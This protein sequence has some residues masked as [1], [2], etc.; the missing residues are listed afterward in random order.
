[1]ENYK[2]LLEESRRKEKELIGQFGKVSKK[3]TINT[4][5]EKPTPSPSHKRNRSISIEMVKESAHKRRPS[6]NSSG[7]LLKSPDRPIFKNEEATPEKNETKYSK[8]LIDWIDIGNIMKP[9]PI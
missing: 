9:S 8:E 7:P 1:M 2:I 3:V 4:E 6:E 5:R